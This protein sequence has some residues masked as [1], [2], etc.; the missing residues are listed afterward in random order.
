LEKLNYL[1]YY[2]VREIEKLTEDPPLSHSETAL[3]WAGLAI[4]LPVF[5][6]Y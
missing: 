1:L 5:I 2:Y 3:R 6:L 4:I